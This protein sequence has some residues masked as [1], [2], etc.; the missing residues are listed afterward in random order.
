M[1]ASAPGKASACDSAT[2]RNN[3]IRLDL[4]KLQKLLDILDG[5]EKERPR[6]NRKFVRWPY[7]HL[8]VQLT[9]LHHDGSRSTIGVAC[10][11]IS[12]GGLSFLH[13]AYVYP[14]SACEISLPHVSGK[15]VTIAGQIVRC[16]HLQGIIHEV[17]VKFDTPI[18]ISDFVQ[19][20]RQADALCIEKVDTQ[21]LRGSVLFVGGSELDREVVRHFLRDTALRVSCVNTV[22]EAQ[23]RASEGTDLIFLDSEFDMS[24]D[25]PVITRLRDDGVSCP[26]VALMAGPSTAALHPATRSKC[27]AIVAKPITESTLQ[28]VIAGLV[29][30]D[31]RKGLFESSLEA[32]HPS[33]CLIHS[34]VEEARKHAEHLK[35][36]M[37][38]NDTQACVTLCRQ[39]GGVA[40]VVGFELLGG[41]ARKA[42]MAIATSGSL[43]EATPEIVR[44]IATCKRV[45]SS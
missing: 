25:P 32:M 18:R 20:G 2:T 11:N 38:H 42:E 22:E 28:Q 34:F 12:C 43:E 37:A 19:E 31:G 16:C 3:S 4:P 41:L 45:K 33:R 21:T 27:D 6:T 30:P 35:E 26:I 1:K 7:R 10:R 29:R 17:G 24:M 8:C 14:K 36:A 5:R 39:I 23:K 9:I 15:T 44:L 40:P 13:N